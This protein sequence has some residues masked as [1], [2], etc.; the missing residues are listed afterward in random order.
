MCDGLIGAAKG[1]VRALAFHYRFHVKIMLDGLKRR[2]IIQSID[3]EFSAAD[4]SDCK[5]VGPIHRAIFELKPS[6]LKIR[7]RYFGCGRLVERP[8]IRTGSDI[9]RERLSDH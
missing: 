9:V 1:L 8:C 4:E 6:S 7:F 3:S 2:C 5:R